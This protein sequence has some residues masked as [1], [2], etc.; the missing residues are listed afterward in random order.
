MH[1]FMH[2]LA[3]LAFVGSMVDASA[4]ENPKAPTLESL[5]DTLRASEF[6]VSTSASGTLTAPNRAQDLRVTFDADGLRVAPRSRDRDAFTWGLAFAGIGRRGALEAPRTATPRAHG[7]RVEYDRG[8]VVEWYVNDERGVEHGFTIDTRVAGEGDLVLALGVRGSLAPREAER[9][10]DFVAA[11]GSVAIRYDHLHVFDAE[12][13]TLPA[14]LRA[15]A[16]NVYLEV[17][18]RDA[19]YPITID[20]LATSPSWDVGSGQG[21]SGFG[22]SVASAGDVNGDG[23]ADVIVGAPYFDQGTND[24]GMAFVFLG[25][26]N[27]VASTSAWSAEGNQFGALFG[28]SV[29]SA[30]DVNGDGFG[31]VIVGAPE[32]NVAPGQGTTHEGQAYVYLG[33]ATGLATT[34]A[35]TQTV[36]Q[37]NALFGC[38]VASAGDVDGDG[39]DDVVVGAK[40]LDNGQ[41]NEGRAFLFRGSASG[42][43]AVPAWTAESDVANAQFGSSVASAGDVNGD[44][45]ADVVVGAYN[46]TNGITS[47]GKA[48]QYLGSAT[49]LAP[50]PAWTFEGSQFFALFGYSV[51]SAGDVNGDG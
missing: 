45:F 51:A 33:S 49:G 1:S 25:S 9:G 18:D 5:I 6:H 20:P 7:A 37:S 11:D 48:Y 47:E 44:G 21:F 2:L 24:E 19:R 42:L 15:D 10:I 34:P 38:S 14:A 8:S 28:S 26:A 16:S 4:T 27:G 17:D 22:L 32:I 29:A 12:G 23:F 50:A 3:G 39:F 41:S 13:V 36:P 46:L 31:D 30:G 40:L 35:W 43:A